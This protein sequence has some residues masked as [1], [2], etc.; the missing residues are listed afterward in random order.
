MSLTAPTEADSFPHW[1]IGANVAGMDVAPLPLI[2][3]DARSRAV[4]PGH[5][6]AR[7]LM[8]ENGDG[9]IL[10]MPARVVSEAQFEYDSDQELQQLLAAAA[11]SPTVRR[12]RPRS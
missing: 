3:T 12:N 2:Q 8:V 6:N 9:S 7:F 4:L 5:P 11:S 1:E 10:L